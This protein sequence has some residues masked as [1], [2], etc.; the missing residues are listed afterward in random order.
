[1]GSITCR[2]ISRRSLFRRTRNPRSA[3]ATVPSGF[4]RKG[5]FL[6]VLLHWR[7]FLTLEIIFIS[8][9][10]I[11]GDYSALY[12]QVLHHA[13]DI[14]IHIFKELLKNKYTHSVHCF[15]KIKIKTPLS[16]RGWR[17]CEWYRVLLLTKRIII[18]YIKYFAHAVVWNDKRNFFAI[19]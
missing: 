13:W 2:C 18:N 3:V 12:I 10:R 6:R 19:T 16:V 5:I 9:Q 17:T 8:S 14:I 7:Y 11:R 15:S 1:M 4:I